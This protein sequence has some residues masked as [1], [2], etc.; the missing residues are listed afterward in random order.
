MINKL[1]KKAL[2]TGSADGIGYSI[3]VKLLKQNIEV[4]AVDKYKEKLKK[5]SKDFINY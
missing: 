1:Y 2:I 5:I 4:I 3:L